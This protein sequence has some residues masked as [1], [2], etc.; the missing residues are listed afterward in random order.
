M[1]DLF[2]GLHGVNA[3]C[4]RK[5]GA[6]MNRKVVVINGQRVETTSLVVKRP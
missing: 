4:G 5:D 3:P 1:A 2:K 6:T